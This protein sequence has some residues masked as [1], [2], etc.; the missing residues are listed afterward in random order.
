MNPRITESTYFDL[1]GKTQN[2]CGF[3]G[4]G[5]DDKNADAALLLPRSLGGQDDMDNLMACCKVC[6]KLK[7]HMTVED[8]RAF[9]FISISEVVNKTFDQIEKVIHLLV[10]RDRDAIEAGLVSVNVLL[11]T[12][13]SGGAH[14]FFFERLELEEVSNPNPVT[15]GDLS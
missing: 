9:V 1:L 13:V 11:R 4:T 15:V 7:G 8:F 5:L 6:K 2:C 14:S 3:C 10:E 12:R